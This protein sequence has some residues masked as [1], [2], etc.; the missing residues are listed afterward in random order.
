MNTVYSNLKLKIKNLLT[1]YNRLPVK[2]KSLVRLGTILSLAIALPLFVWGV[3]N[4]NYNLNE[5]AA[6]GEPGICIPQNKVI[7]VTPEGSIGTCHNLQTAINAVDSDGYTIQIEPGYYPFYSTININGKNNL[8]ITGNPNNGPAATRL[9]SL[10]SGGWG[11]FVQN[12]TGS[13]EYLTLD[14]GSANGLLSII[15]SNNYRVNNNILNSQSSHTMDVQNSSNVAVVYNEILSSA[16]ALEIHNSNQLNIN[17][18]KIHDAYGGIGINASS[19][20]NI[21]GNLIYG[22]R[23][24]A[25]SFNA[26]PNI[27]NI[28]NVLVRNN[29]FTNNSL[30][31]PNS[32]TIRLSGTAGTMLE[33]SRNIVSVGLG[34]G[35]KSDNGLSFSPF[36]YN[37]IFSHNPNYMGHVSQTGINGNISEDPLLNSTNYVYCPLSTSP[38]IFGDINMG[39]Y[40]GWTAPCTI[41][42]SP[43]PSVS[44]SPSSIPTSSPTIQPT[45]TPTTPPTPQSLSFLFRFGGVTG[46]DANGAK[47]KVYIQT[48]NNLLETPPII[49]EHQGSGIYKASFRLSNALPA[50]R[51][52]LYLKG[53][54]HIRAR[55][56]SVNSILTRCSGSASSTD[57]IMI[58]N[59][60]GTYDLTNYSLEPGDVYVQDGIADYRDFR[61]I[62]TLMSKPTTSLTDTDKLTGDLNYDGVINIRD[63]FLMRQ[64]LSVRQDDF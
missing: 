46:G 37:D 49:T 50:G 5:R 19:N 32:A 31:G 58:D 29:T 63:A 4:L 14:G 34:A 6:S 25:L 40:M 16:G 36:E 8:K 64:S 24:S 11:I 13:I 3:I 30:S 54:K 2:T 48:P 42:A 59:Q 17:N 7:V 15:Y 22:I 33:F 53:E 41:M 23:E 27:G 60:G 55:Y 1:S 51:Y 52:P 44:P 38:V 56:C 45:S 61:K 47:V 28:H 57:G 26:Y 12:S 10:G 21:I 39:G 62:I 20:I 43:P 35:I 18:N 9:S